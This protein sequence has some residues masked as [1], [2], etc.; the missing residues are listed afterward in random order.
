[1]ENSFG[2]YVPALATL[3]AALIAGVIARSNLIASKE[4]KISEFRQAWIDSLREELAMFFSSA[5]LMVRWMEEARARRPDVVQE[6][7][8]ISL[9]KI[10]EIRHA[11]ADTYYKIKFRLNSS[12]E[13]HAQLLGLIDELIKKQNNY[14]VDVNSNIDEV[15]ELA[16]K[17]S[18]QAIIVL[19]GE[20]ETVKRGEKEYQQAVQ[21]TKSVPTVICVL[22]TALMVYVFFVDTSQKSKGE[23]KI[24]IPTPASAS[25]PLTSSK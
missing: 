2:P 16:E 22:L 12:Q 25:K 20:W 17:A 24:N 18:L 6:K 3:A 11:A 14:L 21:A 10:T 4:T 15:F 7:F 13:G 5:R 23:V 1:M 19:K 8:N 9:E